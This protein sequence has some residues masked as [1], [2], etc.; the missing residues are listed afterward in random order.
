MMYTIAV[1]QGAKIHLNTTA[2]AIDPE[3]RE[4]TLASGKTLTADV[5]VGADGVS[6]LLRPILLA[7]QDIQ[8]AEEP[9]L[10]MYR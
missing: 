2:V 4:V 9:S 6:G 10:C 7:E 5:I 3:R 8:E 1:K